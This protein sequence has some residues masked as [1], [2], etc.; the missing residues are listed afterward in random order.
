MTDQATTFGDDKSQQQQTTEQQQQTTQ[1]Q[2]STQPFLVIGD[3]TFQTAE[4]M[5]NAWMHSQAHIQTLESERKQ[6]R[7]V[8]A[9]IPELESALDK[10][11]QIQA[12]QVT[13]Q[14]SGKTEQTAGASNEELV[15]KAAQLAANAV[16]EHLKSDAQNEKDK[17][18]FADCMSTATKVYGSD[19]VA[20]VRER[21]AQ[22]GM[23]IVAVDA[24]AKSSP[25]GWKQL[26]TPDFKPNA[27]SP[28]VNASTLNTNNQQQQQQSE[29]PR[30]VMKMSSKE[31][32]A[33]VQRRL[34]EAA[35]AVAGNQ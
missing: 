17:N 34:A 30:N 25:A 6:D 19:A 8:L 35:A 23:S 5:A 14:Q 7:E 16:K 4:E 20:K 28:D 29:Q 10:L 1:Q 12:A 21:A 33:E 15:N 24:L 3:R 32:A 22:L 2:Q 31:R 11:Q 27:G 26:F 18:N 13:Q 9:K